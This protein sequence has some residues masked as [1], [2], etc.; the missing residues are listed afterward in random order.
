MLLQAQP[1]CPG[2]FHWPRGR[3]DLKEDDSAVGTAQEKGSKQGLEKFGNQKIHGKMA[4]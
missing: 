4:C 2:V 3:G 1:C